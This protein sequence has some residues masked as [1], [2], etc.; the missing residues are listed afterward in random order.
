MRDWL[1]EQSMEILYILYHCIFI[2]F[3]SNFWY[4]YENFIPVK[5]NNKSETRFENLCFQHVSNS[6]GLQKGGKRSWTHIR[7]YEAYKFATDVWEIMYSCLCPLYTD[8]MQAVND[9]TYVAV[10]G[11]VTQNVDVLLPY[12]FTP[13]HLFNPNKTPPLQHFM[14]RLNNIM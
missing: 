6:V 12:S 8:I 1:I 11:D 10:S 5:W 9:M 4:T 13:P 7:F 2:I 3:W 14:L